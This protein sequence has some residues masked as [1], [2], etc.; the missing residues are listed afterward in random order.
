MFLL[1]LY[2]LQSH[3]YVSGYGLSFEN[4]ANGGA[5]ESLFHDASEDATM[6]RVVCKSNLT[7]AAATSLTVAFL[8]ALEDLDTHGSVSVRAIKHKAAGH[9]HLHHVC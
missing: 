1:C 6:F 2:T 3:W 7:M 4:L 8:Q 9:H 5:K